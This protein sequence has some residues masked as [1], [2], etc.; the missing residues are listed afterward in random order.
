MS[1]NFIYRILIYVL[2]ICL[3]MTLALWKD[4]TNIIVIIVFAV[5]YGY[6]SMQQD[7]YIEELIKNGKK[8][9][10]K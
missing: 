3:G 9:K 7:K 6:V 10:K 5:I 2:G 4:W 8:I 1:S